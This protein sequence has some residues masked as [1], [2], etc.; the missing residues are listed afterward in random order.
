[1]KRVLGYLLMISLIF[2]IVTCKKN[3]SSE[4]NPV[5]PPLSHPL[6]SKQYYSVS[7]TVFNV[8]SKDYS[9]GIIKGAPIVIDKDTV[10][11]DAGG[12][13]IFNKINVGSHNINVSL[14]EY[15]HYTK[16][17]SI[18]SDTINQIYLYGTKEDYFPIQEN[19][20][21]KFKYSSGSSNGVYNI[22][23]KGEALWLIKSSKQVGDSKVYEVVETLIDTTKIF[24]TVYSEKI[25]TLITSF[26]ISENSSKIIAFKSSI[27]DGVSFDR[28][29]DHRLGEVNIVISG[30]PMLIITL[31]KNVGLTKINK[32]SDRGSGTTYELIQ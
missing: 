26:T 23:I 3:D 4:S 13:Y 20:Q 25:D 9:P 8:M 17:I 30:N 1:M 6:P 2:V 21:K 10:I 7:G 31:K 16:T 32:Y 5:S 27:L 11:S 12:R 18:P 14:P 29:W 28:Y 19:S 15:E 24:G 22:Y